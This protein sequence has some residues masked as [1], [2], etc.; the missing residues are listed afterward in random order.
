MPAIRIRSYSEFVSVF[1]WVLISL[2]LWTCLNVEKMLELLLLIPLGALLAFYLTIT[3]RY[4]QFSRQGIPG[5]KPIFPFGNTKSSILKQRNVVYDVDDVYRWDKHVKK[6]EKFIKIFLF[7][8]NFKDKAP[9]SGFFALFTPYLLATDPDLIKQMF[10]RDFKKFKNNDFTVNSS[11]R[12]SCDKII[13]L[14]L[15]KGQSL[16][17]SNYS[18]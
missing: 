14:F 15:P 2:D 5:P 8:R 4:R 3:F 6:S 7:R 11:E 16:E 1:Q 17:G 12:S 9:F 10:I 13:K 18:S